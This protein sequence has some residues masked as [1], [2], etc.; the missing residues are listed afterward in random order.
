MVLEGMRDRV[1]RSI[2]GIHTSGKQ[3]LV[4]TLPVQYLASSLSKLVFICF[5]RLNTDDSPLPDIPY[6]PVYQHL[7]FS[8]T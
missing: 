2:Y 7:H 5:V 1:A 6:A 4:M 8:M 3:H